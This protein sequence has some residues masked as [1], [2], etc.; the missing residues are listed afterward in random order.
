[1]NVVVRNIEHPI[2]RT[3]VVLDTDEDGAVIRAAPLRTSR[4]RFDGA[5][6]AE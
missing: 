2:G 5:V 4:K 1:M 6:F 3:T